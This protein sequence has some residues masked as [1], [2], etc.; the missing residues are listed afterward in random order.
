LIIVVAKCWGSVHN[1]AN[2]V[3]SDR[4]MR[5]QPNIARLLVYAAAALGLLAS[6]LAHGQS[7]KPPRKKDDAKASDQFAASIS[8]ASDSI[9][10]E[11]QDNGD[12][13]A[14][15]T[16]LQV[17]FDQVVAFG[18]TTDKKLFRDAAL[19]LRLATL[20][21]QAEESQRVELLEFLLS[22]PSLAG[23]LAFVVKPEDKPAD[24]LAVLARLRAAHEK[25]LNAHATLIAALCVVHDRPL[26]RQI[27][28]NSAT[29]P[30]VVRLFEYFVGNEKR[31]FFGL[32][33]VPAEVLIYVVDSTASIDE[34]AWAI[35]RYAGNRNVGGLFFDVD[36]DYDHFKDGD[37]KKVT[38]A[39]WNLPN[40]LKIGGVCADQ[41]YFAMSVGKAIGVPTAYVSASSSEVGHAWVGF[42]QGDG[43][44]VW[45]NF[46]SGR[47][48]SYRG[49]RGDLQDPQTRKR[50][51]DST[52]SLLAGALQVKELDRQYA[53]AMTDAAR[54]LIEASATAD[55]FA[56]PKPENVDAGGARPV[57]TE[58]ALKFL[59]AGL[60]ACPAHIDGWTVIAK[61]AADGK[62]T[63]ERKGFWEGA[64]YRLCGERHP[65][66]YLDLLEP[67]F[68]TVSDFQLQNKYWNAAFQK[69]ASS[70]PDLAASVRMSQ[71][72]MWVK[73][74]RLDIAGQCYDD[75]INRYANAG[76]FVITALVK[77]EQMVRVNKGD[78]RR[79]VQ[80]YE[81]AWSQI[82]R[83]REMAP[84]FARQSNYYR[85]GKMYAQKLDE[86]GRTNDA[87]RVR[88]AV[89]ETKAGR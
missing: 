52:V 11:I 39:G 84:E 67:M 38:K 16:S 20:V 44:S 43:R 6:S 42:L 72:A 47:Y 75:V 19:N 28:E 7:T 32:K 12:F 29:A 1:P 51:P 80:A 35:N 55:S 66:F 45:W 50:I 58:E 10:K 68:V 61:L 9:F 76:P 15:L 63:L 59:E 64:A 23:T 77:G 71:A 14:G 57:T 21:S 36:Y 41:A 89:G 74:D 83:P 46:S 3:R 85:V 62:L 69:F 81:N 4:L 87:A 82:E 79:I 27:N 33:T 60:T 88:A 24:V 30:D 22:N 73:A 25:K 48:D 40:I 86:V 70:R 34:M 2:L 53:A 31:L 8:A 54:R 18:A 65:D 17:I 5:Q 13:A 37:V 49:V 26:T 56:P 78:V